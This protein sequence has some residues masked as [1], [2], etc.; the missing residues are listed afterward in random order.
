MTEP[1]G[2]ISDSFEGGSSEHL[3]AAT[4][5]PCDSDHPYQRP[6]NNGKITLTTIPFSRP[7]PSADIKKAYK[8]LSRKFH[9]D[10]NKDAGAE[11]KFVEITQAYEALSDPKKRQIYDR[12]GEE[13]LKAHEGGQHATNP[14]DVFANFFGRG[15]AHQDSVR[16]GPTMV[17]EFEVTLADIYMGNSVDFMIKKK[18]LCDHCR[19]TGAQTDGDIKNC[20]TSA[21]AKL[22][23]EFASIVEDKKSLITLATTTLTWRKVCQKVTKSCLK[24]RAISPRNGKLAIEIPFIKAQLL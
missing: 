20:P 11:E 21:K 16:R 13:G 8:R 5:H 24:E 1:T 4:W 2:R 12:H 15:A 23:Q 10:R 7:I 6:V 19:G 9:P 17:S 22:L 3:S 14:F 18:I